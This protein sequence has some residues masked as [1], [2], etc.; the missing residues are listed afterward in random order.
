M[1][2]FN[3]VVVILLLLAT[4]IV[5]TTVLVVPRPAIEV[6]QQQWLWNL[7]MNLSFVPPLTLLVVGVALALLVD[8]V[9]AVLIWLEIRRRR[10]RAIKVR[11]IS[12]GQ[13]ELTVD[14]VSRRVEHSISQLDG[15][16]SVEPNVLGK[17]RGV[18]VVIGL[19]TS[20]EV[21]VPAKAEEVCQVTREIVEDKMGLKL[22]K[23]KV[24][25]KHAPYPIG[26]P[27]VSEL[28]LASPEPPVVPEP[29]S[30]PPEP[31]AAYE[32]V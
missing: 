20:P 19:E 26:Q 17:R 32:D 2:T 9:C 21:N 11:S 28:T 1:N 18:E 27:V 13:A 6:L 3:R 24:N 22:R 15:V 12:G 8:V 16:I 7:D 14:S 23:V 4:I 10:P 5:M 29:T 25:I 31:P 30:H